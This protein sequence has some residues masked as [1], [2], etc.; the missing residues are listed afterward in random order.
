MTALGTR[1]LAALR[2][3][4]YERPHD[5]LARHS[6]DRPLCSRGGDDLDRHQLRG[7][8]P[9]GFGASAAGAER[10]RGGLRSVCRLRMPTR[11]DVQRSCR[12]PHV[13]SG[14]S[15]N[16]SSVSV[17]GRERAHQPVRSDPLRAGNPL[18]GRGGGREVR[19][20]RSEVGVRV[21]PLLRTNVDLP[22]Q[23][24]REPSRSCRDSAVC[25]GPRIGC[26]AVLASRCR[27]CSPRS[28]L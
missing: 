1:C 4:G 12:R 11:A 24:R 13:H 14:D 22:Q 23:R 2:R 20:R 18:R 16:S 27:S 25:T 3:P 28:S 5:S 6:W 7:P 10:H 9:R 8:G 17:S 21:A 19:S 15:S 26:I